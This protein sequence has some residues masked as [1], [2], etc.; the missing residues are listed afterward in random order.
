[1]GLTGS[2]AAV[3][4]ASDGTQWEA[5]KSGRIAGRPDLSKDSCTSAGLRGRLEYW[6]CAP[7][8]SAMSAR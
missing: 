7:V 3:A 1:V 5:C 8:V 4:N 6:R 2:C